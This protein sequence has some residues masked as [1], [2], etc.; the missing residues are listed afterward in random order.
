MAGH[1]IEYEFKKLGVYTVYGTAHSN[2]YRNDL[3]KLDATDDAALSFLISDLKPNYIINCVGALIAQSQQEPELA[4]RLNA[5]LPHTLARLANG[6]RAKV[7]HISTDCVFSGQRGSY[8]EDDFRDADDVYG[9]TKALGELR[10]SPHVTLRTSI[11]GPELDRNGSGLL[12]WFT[13]QRGTVKGFANAIWTGVTT[14]ELA[15]VI[16]ACVDADLQGLYHITNGTPISK[17]ELLTL[18]HKLF[19]NEVSTIERYEAFFSDKSLRPSTK[20]NFHIPSYQQMLESLVEHPLMS[21]R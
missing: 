18:F 14:L 7:I 19:P 4:I 5:L 21:G 9:R 12:A 1:M 16:K 8:S 17:Y 15:H 6:N 20:H 11:I 3:I 2:V 13:R 10:G